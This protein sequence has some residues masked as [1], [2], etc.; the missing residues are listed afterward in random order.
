MRLSWTGGGL[1]IPKT[2]SLLDSIPH[3]AARRADTAATA[4]DDPTENIPPGAPSSAL[5]Y[6]QYIC[7]VTTAAAGKC[8]EQAWACHSPEDAE[9][10][11][12]GRGNADHGGVERIMELGW[13]SRGPQE[14]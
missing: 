13:S 5:P 2:T 9:S 3:T 10:S 11:P 14:D 4:A 1:P 6:A 12:G 7:P 8:P